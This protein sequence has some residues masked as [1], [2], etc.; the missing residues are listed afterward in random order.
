MSRDAVVLLHGLARSPRSMEPLARRLRSEGYA[1]LNFGYPSRR[2]TV[3]QLAREHLAPAVA[4]FVARTGARL[5]FVTHSMGGI[6]VRVLLRAQTPPHLG[7]VVM[8]APPSQG[9][10]LV[11]RMGAWPLFRAVNGPAGRELGTGAD[12]IPRRLGAVGYPVGVIAGSRSVN[13]LLSLLFP[14]A[15]D[16][17]VSVARAALD[18]MADFLVMPYSH[19][20][21]ARRVA[22]MD[23]VVHF[24]EHGRFL[25]EGV[26]EVFAQ[27]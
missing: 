17:K 23:Q 6:L 15:N 2:Q 7:H 27:P 21:I 3:E 4:D 8:I 25:R 24:L 18:G 19:T 12:E 11:D 14:G 9:S 13:P 26:P 10:E 5:H 1:V 16:G 20:F 22:V